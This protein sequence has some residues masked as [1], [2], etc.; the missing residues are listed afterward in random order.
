MKLQRPW[1]AIA[2]MAIMLTA[3]SAA[4]Y[5]F[6]AGAP[7]LDAPVVAADS[8]LPFQLESF[9]SQAMGENR[10]YGVILPPGYDQQPQRRYPVIVLL[11]G[12]H[13]DALSYRDKYAIASILQQLYS[14]GKLPPSI[15]IMP[16]GNDDRG[17]NPLFDPAYYNGTHGKLDT[18]IGTEL[19][20]VIKSR[21]RTINDPRFWAMGGISSGGWGA[22]NIGLRH[23]DTFN[24]LFSHSGYFTDES[25]AANSPEAFVKQVVQPLS[26]QEKQHLHFYLDAGEIDT[27]FVASTKQFHQTLDQLGIANV[28]YT[29]PG[30]H[31]LAG[32]DIGW[33]YFRKHL[34]DSLSYVGT[35]F[36]TASQN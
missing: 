26:P 19:V 7:Q 4:W 27:D 2:G 31:G 36:E 33:N 6:V 5:T 3:S 35:Q 20:Q 32:T 11:H 9:P 21:Y 16:D 17:S 12:G 30:G 22:F 23:L 10:Q 18:L 25:G 13:D 14:T 28:F 34:I 29:F 8:G 1:L 24:I 15:V